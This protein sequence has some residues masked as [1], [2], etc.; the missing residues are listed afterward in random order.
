MPTAMADKPVIETFRALPAAA[1]IERYRLGVEGGGLDRRVFELNDEQL[2]MA[3]LP[4][5][6]VGRWPVRV[7]LGH[8]ADA[9]LF[10]AGRLRQV[11]AEDSPTFGVWDENAFIESGLYTGPSQPIGGFIATIYTLRKWLGPW[12]ATLSD[13]QLSRQAL[14]PQRGPQTTRIILEYATWHLEHPA[15]FLK[16]KCERLTRA[17]TAR[18]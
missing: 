3:W 1:L 14:H 2:D 8:L 17:K 7:L 16:A 11:V 6:N 9:D 15:W 18:V 4:E 10:F 13:A 12:L 5:A